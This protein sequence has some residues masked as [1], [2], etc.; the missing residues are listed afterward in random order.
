MS[1]PEHTTPPRQSPQRRMNG[2]LFMIGLICGALLGLLMFWEGPLLERPITVRI[3]AE[4][5]TGT[6]YVLTEDVRLAQA[7]EPVGMLRA[8]ARIARISD[9]SSAQYFSVWVNASD[10]TLT[11]VKSHDVE[12]AAFAIM[13]RVEQHSPDSPDFPGL[14]PTP[15][16]QPEAAFVTTPT[17]GQQELFASSP[18]TRTTT[19]TGESTVSSEQHGVPAPTPTATPLPAQNATPTATPTGVKFLDVTPT[20]EI[21]PTPDATITPTSTPTGAQLLVNA[22][23]VR[24]G[25]TALF[26]CSLLRCSSSRNKSTGY[27][28]A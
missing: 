25:E 15:L 24:A 13:T 3:D 9:H 27:C 20:P 26:T 1:N 10:E 18:E 7:G 17:P 21:S 6:L 19:S 5:P 22:V 12:Q 23:S 16:L 28:S 8:G 14:P 11:T 2:M 4:H